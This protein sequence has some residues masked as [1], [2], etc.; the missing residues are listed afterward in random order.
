MILCALSFN[1]LDRGTAS[2][3]FDPLL[4]E[5]SLAFVSSLFIVTPPNA[6]FFPSLDSTPSF[7]PSLEL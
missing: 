2:V 4:P 6:P 7:L 1:V 5:L 3:A